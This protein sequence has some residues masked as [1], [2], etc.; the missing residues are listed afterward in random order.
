MA[1]CQENGTTI[2]LG[3]KDYKVGEVVGGEEREV[4]KISIKAKERRCPYCGG[5][6]YSKRAFKRCAN[7]HRNLTWKKLPK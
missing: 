4:V 5:D 2:L 6:H 3:L 7:S 1:R